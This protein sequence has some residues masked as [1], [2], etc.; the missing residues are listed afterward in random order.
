MAETTTEK[1]LPSKIQTISDM[2]ETL[3]QEIEDIKSGALDDAKARHVGRFRGMQLKTAELSLQY[4]RLHKGRV[5][6]PEM[7][8]ITSSEPQK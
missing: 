2:M 3:Q 1:K 7:K 8:L 6:D 4:A 5:P